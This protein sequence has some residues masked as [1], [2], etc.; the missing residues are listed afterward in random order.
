MGGSWRGRDKV[1][2]KCCDGVGEGE[3]V[4]EFEDVVFGWWEDFS[5]GWVLDVPKWTGGVSSKLAWINLPLLPYIST[6][7]FS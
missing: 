1:A 4:G 6:G 5:W 3:G 2:G 7:I